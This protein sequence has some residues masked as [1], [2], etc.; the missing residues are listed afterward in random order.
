MDL[1]ALRIGQ[2]KSS[3]GFYFETICFISFLKWSYLCVI[4]FSAAV[5]DMIFYCLI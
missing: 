2:V 5:Y 4:Y 3:L 1:F